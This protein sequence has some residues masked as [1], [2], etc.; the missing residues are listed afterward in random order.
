[1]YGKS[2]DEERTAS[3]YNSF[4][5]ETITLENSAAPQEIVGATRPLSFFSI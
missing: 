2:D 1:M 5:K 3:A 4:V